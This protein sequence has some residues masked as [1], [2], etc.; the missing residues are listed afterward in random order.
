VLPHYIY[1]KLFSFCFDKDFSGIKWLVS[2]HFALKKHINP[3]RKIQIYR[4]IDELKIKNPAL[5]EELHQVY[6]SILP[7]TLFDW[8]IYLFSR[9]FGSE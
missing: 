9:I 2:L 3:R 5:A 7:P 8:I 4:I 1:S 6:K